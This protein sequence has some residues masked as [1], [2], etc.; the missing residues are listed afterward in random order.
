MVTENIAQ[1]KIQLIQRTAD[2][3]VH[4]PLPAHIPIA[5]PHPICHLGALPVL[6]SPIVVVVDEELADPE[7]NHGV[8]DP[9]QLLIHVYYIFVNMVL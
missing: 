8:E 7:D 2:R 3:F 1:F 5:I 9:F 4:N 6:I